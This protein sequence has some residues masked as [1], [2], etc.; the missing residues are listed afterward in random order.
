MKV[1]T[2]CPKCKTNKISMRP[3]TLLFPTVDV[4]QW[5]CDECKYEW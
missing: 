5:I 4:K 1:Y 2:N 3:L